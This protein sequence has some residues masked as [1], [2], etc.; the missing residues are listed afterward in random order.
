MTV[1]K[2]LTTEPSFYLGLEILYFSKRLP[3]FHDI[4]FLISQEYPVLIKQWFL[5]THFSIDHEIEEIFNILIIVNIF[6]LIERIILQTVYHAQHIIL[7][8][9][10][11]EIIKYP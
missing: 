3:L 11:S 4:H 8:L 1:A 7:A 9:H 6:E 5:D 2:T 10:F